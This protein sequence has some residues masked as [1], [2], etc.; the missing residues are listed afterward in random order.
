MKKASE[1]ERQYDQRFR[2]FKLNVYSLICKPF[3]NAHL[4]IRPT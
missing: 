3:E 2:L 4:D 1:S